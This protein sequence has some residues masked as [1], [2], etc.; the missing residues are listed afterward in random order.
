[1][2]AYIYAAAQV[3]LYFFRI[4][5]VW[6]PD[7]SAARL[8]NPGQVGLHPGQLGR[9][10]L[11]RVVFDFGQLGPLGFSSKFKPLNNFSC[12]IFVCFMK[13]DFDELMVSK[14]PV[15]ITFLFHEK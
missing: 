11:S 4:Y 9:A 14:S 2:C 5:S 7:N 1:M 15:K 6:G 12:D 8:G 3:L 10:E 13:K